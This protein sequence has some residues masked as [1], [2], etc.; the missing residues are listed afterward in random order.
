MAAPRRLLRAWNLRARKPL[1]QHFL[2][3][4]AAAD[5]I[6]AHARL[7]DDDVVLE[8][9]AGLGALTVR[10][11]RRA[12]AV[13]A[14]ERDAALIPLLQSELPS[15]HRHRVTLLSQDI[16]RVDLDAIAA[17]EGRP[18][19][20]VGNLPY[21]ISSQILVRLIHHRSSI[22]RAVLM[23]QS[24]LAQRLMASPGGR[25]YGRLT[26]M[27]RY[28]ADIERLMGVGGG[29]FYPKP[30]IDSTVVGVCFRPPPV[31]FAG[32]ERFFFRVIKAGFSKRRKTL[33]NA[34]A[35]SDLALD[36]EA[37]RQAL[38][39]S[40]IDPQ[41]RAETL[42]VAEFVK[43]SNGLAQAVETQAPDH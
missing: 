7:S 38:V 37:A 12:A 25:D 29:Q 23:F 34:L 11:V 3:D 26:V 36:A 39:R 42:D 27:L 28:C 31:Q 33:K 22:D 16:L 18:L 14:V 2:D 20:V 17:K 5:R 35:S 9:G 8:I 21:N 41:R 1:G 10:L 4:E 40:G 13:Y 30:K 6:V 32:D 24:E 15:A 43:L 19:V